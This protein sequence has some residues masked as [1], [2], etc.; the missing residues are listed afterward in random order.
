MQAEQRLTACGDFYG[1][2]D[3]NRPYAAFAII[4][5]NSFQRFSSREGVASI[6]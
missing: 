1:S 4:A 3:P 2:S 6:A 5:F